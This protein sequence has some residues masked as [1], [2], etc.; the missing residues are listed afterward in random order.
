[1]HL[2]YPSGRIP[3]QLSDSFWEMTERFVNYIHT[4]TGFNA[5]VCDDQGIIQVSE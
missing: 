3:L 5:I 1:M 2:C 4:E